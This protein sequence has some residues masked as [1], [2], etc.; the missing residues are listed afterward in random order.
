MELLLI[1]SL[2]VNFLLLIWNFKLIDDKI[3]IKNKWYT[4]YSQLKNQ[5]LKK[6]LVEEEIKFKDSNNKL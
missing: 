1:F 6:D 3:K 4:R 5:S 2:L